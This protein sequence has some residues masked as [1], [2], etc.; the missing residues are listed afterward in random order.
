MKKILTT[1][2]TVRQMKT[3]RERYGGELVLSGEVGDEVVRYVY[4]KL[5]YFF[6]F[7]ESKYNFAETIDKVEK[8]VQQNETRR[9]LV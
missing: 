4:V 3:V 9:S 2:E 5:S 8:Y 1:D 7:L 6:F